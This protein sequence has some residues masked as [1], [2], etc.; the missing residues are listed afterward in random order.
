LSGGL[1]VT[2]PGGTSGEFP[3]LRFAGF[4]LVVL[5]VRKGQVPRG[6]PPEQLTPFGNPL[7]ILSCPGIVTEFEVAQARVQEVV[8][9][10]GVL[11]EVRPECLQ[12]LPL[13]ALVE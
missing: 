13:V 2:V 11:P 12:G 1:G 8:I 5:Q 9:G 10:I 4:H 7:K 3:Q 6:L